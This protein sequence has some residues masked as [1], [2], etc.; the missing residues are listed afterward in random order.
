MQA[1]PGPEPAV[2][3]RRIRVG[4]TA[5]RKVG[6]AVIRNRSKRRLR[7]LAREVLARA[8]RSGTDYVLVARAATVERP[9]RALVADL[10][11]ALARVHARLP[12][13]R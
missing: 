12:Q 13:A 4:V 2:G 3:E 10:E 5:S 11:G 8:G 1:A 6:G 9:F 7:A